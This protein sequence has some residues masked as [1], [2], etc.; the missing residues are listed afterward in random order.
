[1]T[2]ASSTSPRQAHAPGRTRRPVRLVALATATAVVGT[3]CVLASA[4]AAGA[5]T[6]LSQSTGRFL[7]GTA[8]DQSLDAVASIN[9]ESA[10][11]P[12]DPGPNANSLDATL[13]GKVNLPIGNA[14]HLP[15]PGGIQFGAVAQYAK[16]NADGS[17]LGASGAID[18]NGGI[19]VGASN[20]VPK[21]GATIDL[22]GLPG[23][24]ALTDALGNLKLTVGAVSAQAK[25]AARGGSLPDHAA[26]CVNPPYSR[27][28][29]SDQAGRYDVAGLSI[30]ATSNALATAGTTLL[31]TLGT[32]LDTV[33]T[34]LN[35]LG[36]GPIVISGLPTAASLEKITTVT[37]NHG[38]I[39]ASLTDGA[40]HIDVAAL[41]KDL[42]LDLNEL[43][44]NTSLLPYVGTALAK[45]PAAISALLAS[46]S[47]N[48][49]TELGNITVTVAGQPVSAA[50]VL[51]AI[52]AGQG[53]ITDAF[54]TATTALNTQAL[55]PLFDALTK[56]L[57]NIVANG[58]AEAAGKFTESALTLRLGQG[59]TTSA[60][61]VLAK[62]SVG[63][64]ATP[65]TPTVAPTTAIP[66]AVPAG[67]AEHGSP[68]S[69]LAPIAL[70]LLLLT[71]AGAF[72][73]RT[74]TRPARDH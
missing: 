4:P 44:P 19:S 47:T 8:G 40:L 62:A 23:A 60:E 16:A 17:A 3:A 10:T 37:L 71:G 68:M 65:P 2:A 15:G 67:Q 61:I 7:S 41:L 12:G 35:A 46:L 25:Q 5:A 29:N 55:Q 74:R 13:L 50:D 58:Q 14:L 64:G 63:P 45:L 70:L 20:G 52:A 57:L 21:G 18:S 30:D 43:C 49:V 33:K 32:G 38:A 56:N 66:T 31:T 34:A 26:S 22:S 42:G 27:V 39:T 73:L 11:N 1:M 51:T 9:G 48:A 6:I 72:V 24:S 53:Q 59:A 54:T 69:P 28:S 36:G